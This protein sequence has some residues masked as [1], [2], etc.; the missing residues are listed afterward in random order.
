VREEEDLGVM[1]VFLHEAMQVS[2][3]VA[4]AAAAAAAELC[5]F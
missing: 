4:A 3:G 2:K 5:E 1:E